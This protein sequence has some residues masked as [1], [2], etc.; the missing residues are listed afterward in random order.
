[1]GVPAFFRWLSKKYPSIVVHCDDGVKGEYHFDNLYLDMNGIIHPCSHPENKPP[2]ANEEEM[3]LAIFEYV[4][5]IMKIVRPKKLVYMAVDGVAPR[6]KMNQQRS[7]RFRAAQE[8]YEK[9]IQIQKVKDDLLARGIE[10]PEK[11]DSAHFDSNVITPGTDFMINLSEALRSWINRKLSED[12]DDQHSIWPKDL[13]II[14][15]D[16]S[17]PGEGEHKIMDYI[18][19]QKADKNFDANLSHCLYGADADLIMLG[20][21]THEPNF[22]ILREEFK[23]NQPRPCDLCGQLGHELKDCTGQPKP[24]DEQI[25]PADT[26]FIYIRLNVLR[27]Y[28]EKECKSN[29]SVQLNFERFIDDY[30][31]LCFFVGN[32][33]LPHLPSLEIRENAIDRLI[34][35]YKYVMEAYPDAQDMYLT[36]NGHVNKHRVQFVLQELGEY[37]DEI[38]KQRQQ[39]EQNFKERNKRRKLMQA[40]QDLRWLKPEAVGQSERPEVFNNPR[41]EAHKVRMAYKD[42][43]SN[44]AKDKLEKML[45]KPNDNSGESSLKRKREDS[46]N[47]D[48]EP[49]DL[50]QLYNDGWKER[51]YKHKFGVELVD[52]ISKQVADEY[53]RGLCWVMLYYYQGCPDWKW[54]FPFHYAC[55]ASDFKNIEQIDIKFDRMAK[56]FKPLEQLMSVFPAASSKSLPPTWRELMSRNDSP[57]IDFYPTTFKI[58]LNG[59]KAAWMGVALLPFID[60]ERLFAALKTV[61][62]DL[63]DSEKRRNCHGSH[64]IFTSKK[65]SILSDN[66]R[67]AI[68]NGTSIENNDTDDDV[69]KNNEQKAIPA[70]ESEPNL[71]S[72]SLRKSSNYSMTYSKTLC[73]EF[74]DPT[75]SKEFIFPAVMLKNA[76]KPDTVLR[77]QDLDRFERY[78]PIIGMNRRSDRANLAGSG[79]RM[80]ERLVQKEHGGEQYRNEQYHNQYGYQN[81]RHQQYNMQQ[82]STENR[83]YPDNNNNRYNRQQQD[84]NRYSGYNNH[85][86]HS[87]PS[88]QQSN[89]SSSSYYSQQQQ[90]SQQNQYSTGSY[91][92]QQQQSS[93]S[94]YNSRYS[95]APPPPQPQASGFSSYYTSDYVNHHQQPQQQ[96]QQRRGGYGNSSN[97]SYR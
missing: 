24:E 42:Q 13:M 67:N 57:I 14:L 96:H 50:V 79:H 69:N 1:M 61:Y 86:H 17:V 12:Y 94:N 32:D 90:P 54:F 52:R 2:P 81:Y 23:P 18:R 65:H 70:A 82:Y 29:T 49:E 43:G 5:N 63:T 31:F 34:K 19:R 78:R 36:K 68:E 48:S 41:E 95:T 92:Q 80:I 7:R 15:S 39:N 55:F 72:G 51:Y 47:D 8:S 76:R 27:E 10:V 74:Y 25:R 35:I 4:E 88:R 40:E 93:S 3:F 71:I 45:I 87:N 85:N 44:S 21:A 37:E 6:A 28:L 9:L 46:D 97:R 22:T 30:V 84:S 20:L 59:K 26:E 62:N 58:D 56:P 64:L 60:E 77:P 75:Y 33:F 66:I 73:C 89:Y 38:F 53:F 16:S 91:Y 83:Y 11:E